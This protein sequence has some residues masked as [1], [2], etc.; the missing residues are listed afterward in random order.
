MARELEEDPEAIKEQSLKKS[1]RSQKL[2][3]SIPKTNITYIQ[4]GK[5]TGDSD[6]KCK[7]CVIF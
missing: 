6:S 1:N 3:E 7:K 4:K 5:S 2:G